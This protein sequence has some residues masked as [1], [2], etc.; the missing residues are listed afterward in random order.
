MANVVPY[1]KNL[2]SGQSQFMGNGD[3]LVDNSGSP[4]SIPGSISTVS[5]VTSNTNASAGQMILVN[6]ASS[7]ITITLQT[8]SNTAD[9]IIVKKIDSSSNE[10]TIDT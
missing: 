3:T 1:T 5:T 4:I 8:P 6:A 7:E 9:Q 2:S 10:V